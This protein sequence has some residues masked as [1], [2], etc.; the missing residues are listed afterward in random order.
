MKIL[1]YWVVAILAGAIF[2]P[3]YDGGE[4]RNVPLFI[5]IVVIALVLTLIK[6]LRYVFFILKVKKL[7]FKNGYSVTQCHFLPN[8]KNSKNY[9]ISGTKENEILNIYIAKRK[10]SYVTYLFED[11]NTVK[12]YKHTR[13]AL[14]HPTV[15][16]KYIVSPN[17]NTKKTGDI[18][19]FW[20]EED[21][22]EN[23][24]NILLFKKLPCNVKDTKHPRPLDNGDKINEK[25]YLYDIKAFDRIINK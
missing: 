18:Y 19:F 9:H 24:K 7:L 16:Q 14:V 20:H 2:L 4:F 17:V 10:N 5:I 6:I 11:E 23:S 12:L 13:T 1:A 8:F 21:F 22:G 25:V 15:G 3:E